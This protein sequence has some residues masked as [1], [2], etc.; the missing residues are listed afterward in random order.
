MLP[1]KPTYH[2][3]TVACTAS[4]KK[5]KISTYPGNKNGIRLLQ[6]S[7]FGDSFHVERSVECRSPR[8]DKH[9]AL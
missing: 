9:E 4:A 7:Q 2:G 6:V 3:T 5:K 8:N 1:F